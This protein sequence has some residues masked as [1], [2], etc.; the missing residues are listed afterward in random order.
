MAMNSTPGIC[1]SIMRL[2]AFTPAPPTPTTRMTG[3]CGRG[4]PW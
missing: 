4:G 3:M 1:A 2:I